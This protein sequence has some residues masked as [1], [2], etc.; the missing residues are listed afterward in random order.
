MQPKHYENPLV[1]LLNIE[2]ELKAEKD[3]AEMRLASVEDFQA[4]SFVNSIS[5][6]QLTLF[7]WISLLKVVDAEW[8][9]LYNKLQKIHD[10]GAKVVLSRLPIG[11]VAT[12]WFADRYFLP[13]RISS[14]LHRLYSNF[15]RSSYFRDMFCAGRIPQEDLDRV[16]AACGGSI[17][18]TVSQ[19]DESVLGRC[20]K[21]YEQQV[22]SERWMY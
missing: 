7:N 11:D 21:F 14:F 15:R 1:A 19:I 20:D 9:I 22:G 4:V 16:M 3:N 18:T 12:Q 17:L 5:V 10:S 8:N 6:Y 13:P 2:L